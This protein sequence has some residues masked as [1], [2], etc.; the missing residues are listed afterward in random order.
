MLSATDSDVAS[1]GQVLYT[2]YVFSFEVAAV[3]LLVAIIAAISLA[4]RPRQA[5]KAQ[6][7]DEQVRTKASN[8]LRLVDGKRGD[9]L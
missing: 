5:R 3:I 2:D 8:R 1:L 9:P 6:I 4:H 7:I